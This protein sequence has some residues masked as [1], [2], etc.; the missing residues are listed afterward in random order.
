MSV[1]KTLFKYVGG[2]IIQASYSNLGK[3]LLQALDATW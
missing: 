1:I 3:S 2:N